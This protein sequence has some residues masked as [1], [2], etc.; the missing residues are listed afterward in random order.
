MF[1]VKIT[2]VSLILGVSFA[3]VRVPGSCPNVTGTNHNGYK[4]SGLWFEY[5]STQ[6]KFKNTARCIQYHMHPP[7]NGLITAHVSV[8]SKNTGVFLEVEVEVTLT[9]PN[10]QM[11]ATIRDPIFGLLP[12]KYF[13]IEEVYD[14][15]LITLNCDNY[16]SYNEQVIT[17]YTRQAK[18]TT[19]VIRRAQQL[20]LRMGLAQGKFII[21]DNNCN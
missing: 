1:F 14:N 20:A 3:Q 21:Y 13:Y 10:N 12:N 18:P 2:V 7:I 6:D 17:I 15:Y 9:K 16:G 11:H 8:I 4:G 5:A 19:D